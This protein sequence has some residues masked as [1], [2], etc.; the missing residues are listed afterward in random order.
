[1]PVHVHDVAT[2]QVDHEIR[3]GAVTGGGRGEIVLGLGFMLMGENSHVVT[4]ALKAKLAEVQ[5][6]AAQGCE[7]RGALRP[8]GTG[9][10]RHPHRQAQPAGGRAAGHRRSLC[11]PRQPAGRPDR[12]GGH[13]ALHAVRRQLDVAGRHL[14]QPAEPG[15]GGLRPHRG[16]L[17]GDGR[18]CHAPPGAAPA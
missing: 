15:R 2:V 14:R 8:H 16:W 17:G 3:R 4:R 11:L 13:P 10:Q 1:M 7:G 5:K 18:E 12:G 9:G 6:I